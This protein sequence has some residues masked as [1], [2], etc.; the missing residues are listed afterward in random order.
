M[1][2][3]PGAGSRRPSQAPGPFP[4]VSPAE[5]KANGTPLEQY[6]QPEQ[7]RRLGRDKGLAVTG[8]DGPAPVASPVAH[9]VE[10]GGW[11][12]RTALDELGRVA[13]ERPEFRV[14]VRGDV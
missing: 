4:P 2:A 5:A 7:A 8:A 6:A 10:Q 1:R 9:V 11:C 12:G 13:G 3:E 14:H